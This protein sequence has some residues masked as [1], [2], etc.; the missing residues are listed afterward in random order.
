[1]IIIHL[2]YDTHL[3]YNILYIAKYQYIIYNIGSHIVITVANN[4][5]VKHHLIKY[6]MISIVH[7]HVF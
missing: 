2:I 5:I 3:V 6:D 7:H 4:N 1:M